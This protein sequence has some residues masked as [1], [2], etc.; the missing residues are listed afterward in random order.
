MKSIKTIILATVT[1]VSLGASAIAAAADFTLI[2]GRPAGSPT[3]VAFQKFAAAVKSSGTKISAEYHV[4]ARG[5]A[6]ITQ[7]LESKDPNVLLWASPL[8]A[9]NVLRPEGLTVLTPDLYR[10]VVMVAR[11]NWYLATT[12]N[13]K[14]ITSVGQLFDKSCSTR[15]TLATAGTTAKLIGDIIKARSSCD[16]AL[17][18][19]PSIVNAMGDVMSS[20]VDMV[21]IDPVTSKTLTSGGG[22]VLATTG[23]GSNNPEKFPEL[24]QFV[25]G[26]ENANTNLIILASRHMDDKTY[27]QLVSSIRSVWDQKHI[28]ESHTSETERYHAPLYGK[29]LARYIDET[30]KNLSNLRR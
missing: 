20:S 22:N 9:E 10:P 29:D 17:I 28:R 6:S 14:K 7:F 24:N 12:P 19:Y 13:S 4:G 23:H 18:H 26:I 21:V 1:A 15:V 25:P 30:V 27:N 3:E 16:I 11:E 5:A 2:M 8:V